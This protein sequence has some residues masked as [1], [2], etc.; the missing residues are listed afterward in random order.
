M[1]T[2]NKYWNFYE[3]RKNTF[4][5]FYDIIMYEFVQ[6]QCEATIR[7]SNEKNSS[8]TSSNELYLFMRILYIFF[9]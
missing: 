7:S 2:N 9:S 1:K 5:V 6:Q 4:V 3:D 8:P